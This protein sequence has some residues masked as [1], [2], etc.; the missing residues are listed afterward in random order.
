MPAPTVTLSFTFDETG[1]S[2][3]DVLWNGFI[4]GGNRSND[5]GLETLSTRMGIL[6]ALRQVSVEAD[7]TGRRELMESPDLTIRLDV[8]EL[9]MLRR[10]LLLTPWAVQ[11]VEKVQDTL[12]WLNDTHQQIPT[13]VIS[14]PVEQAGMPE[15]LR[16][17]K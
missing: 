10:Y 13:G 12:N 16:G 2:R 6:K 15:L 9:M 11:A 8:G 4:I 14:L 1:K 3:F 17:S 7:P 5:A